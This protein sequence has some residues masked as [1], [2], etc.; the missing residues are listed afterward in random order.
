MT[1]YDRMKLIK[2]GYK[3]L[4]IHTQPEFQI[5]ITNPKGNWI[6]HDKYVSNAAMQREIDRI[7]KNEPLMIFE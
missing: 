4:R 3:L 2:A 1:N 6:K 7:N 5:T